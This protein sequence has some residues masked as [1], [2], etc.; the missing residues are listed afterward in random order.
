MNPSLHA[1][2]DQVYFGATV[3]YVDD[4]DVTRTVTIMGIDEADSS[5]GQ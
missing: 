3:T 2:S 5:L 1:G 4:Q